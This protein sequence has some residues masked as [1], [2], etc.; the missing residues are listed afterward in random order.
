MQADNPAPLMSEPRSPNAGQHRPKEDVE[1]L[2]KLYREMFLI[3]RVEEE[4]ARSYAEG[5][6]GGFLHLYIGQEAVAVGVQSVV[7]KGDEI[8][9]G[10]YQV[11]RTIRNEASIKVDNRNQGQP[12]T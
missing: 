7:E 4:S 2:A 5:K 6:I 11:I 8:I 10:S 3:R 1:H 9:T 12:K